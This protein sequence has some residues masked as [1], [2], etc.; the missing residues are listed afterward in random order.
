MGKRVEQGLIS[1]KALKRGGVTVHDNCF[2]KD[3][4]EAF[5][6]S[7][8][9]LLPVWAGL[10]PASWASWLVEKNSTCVRS[11]NL[12]KLPNSVTRADL[13]RLA[14]DNDVSD[15]EFVVMILAWGG[16]NRRSALSAL[17]H[18]ESWS[19][20]VGQLR[21]GEIDPF[22]AY[23]HFRNLRIDGKLKGMGPAYY[24]KI[25]FFCHPQHNGYIMDQWTA[26]SINLLTASSLVLVTA[27]GPNLR[28]KLVN[29]KNSFEDYKSFCFALDEIT[30]C[31]GLCDSKLTEERLFSA[32]RGKGSWRSYV[33]SNDT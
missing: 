29:D 32:G 10:S 25:I 14:A 13:Y 31:A 11:L 33:I 9:E 24:T 4:L 2:Q 8:N 26:R 15:L 22:S 23:E 19:S 12:A 3:H 16:M 20:V 7:L 1:A 27:Q 30:V 28:T 18:W 17:A 6:G 21:R 5:L